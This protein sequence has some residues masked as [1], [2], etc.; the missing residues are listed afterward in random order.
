MPRRKPHAKHATFDENPPEE[1]DLGHR[2]ASRLGRPVLQ[3][4]TTRGADGGHVPAGTRAARAGTAGGATAASGDE[5][6]VDRGHHSSGL[7]AS[8]LSGFVL[9][10]TPSHE[11]LAKQLH[12]S[13]RASSQRRLAGDSRSASTRGAQWQ[14]R[15][16]KLM[17]SKGAVTFVTGWTLFALFGAEVRTLG[18]DAA[19]ASAF[20]YLFIICMG[21]FS[22]EM[23]VNMLASTWCSSRRFGESRTNLLQRRCGIS[24]YTCSFYFLLD[25]VAILSLLP[26]VPALYE[27]IL[28]SAS[29][30]TSAATGGSTGL[31]A[32]RAGRITRLG[33]RVGRL[34]RMVRLFRLVKLYFLFRGRTLDKGEHQPRQSRIGIRL[35]QRTTRRVVV[36]VLLVLLVLPFFSDSSE[37]LTSG[38][39]V[40]MLHQAAST[41]LQGWEVACA[42]FTGQL[43][44]WPPGA[45]VLEG[46]SR[47]VR[48]FHL[49]FF[50]PLVN[51]TGDCARAE[52][53]E[54]FSTL[55]NGL[56]DGEIQR[57][58][59]GDP[60]RGPFTEAWFNI[61]P[62][63]RDDAFFSML[64][65]LFVSFIL[66]AGSLQVTSDAQRLVLKPIELLA[67]FLDRPALDSRGDIT[68]KDNEGLF[69]TKLLENTVKK[70]V[71]LL[72]LGF[73][74]AGCVVAA[75]H[76]V[77]GSTG[78]AHATRGIR[79]APSSWVGEGPLAALQ[80]TTLAR[81]RVTFAPSSTRGRRLARDRLS[82]G[83]SHGALG[84]GVDPT[85][86][87]ID[88]DA[89][90]APLLLD[91]QVPGRAV[92]VIMMRVRIAGAERASSVLGDRW[93]VLLN[94]VLRIVHQHVLEWGGSPGPSTP[95]GTTCTWTIDD[96]DNRPCL[97]D[98]SSGA[99]K[100]LIA[101]E[102]LGYLEQ[103]RAALGLPPAAIAPKEDHLPGASSALRSRIRTQQ[104]TT[105]SQSL[106]DRPE[107][108]KH[109][110]EL[111][112]SAAFRLPPPKHPPGYVVM[113]KNVE[114]LEKEA[115]EGVLLALPKRDAPAP[116][117]E[118]AAFA[119]AAAASSAPAP[120]PQPRAPVAR[121]GPQA[122]TRT[123]F[124]PKWMTSLQKQRNRW[125]GSIEEGA[126][127]VD[128]TRPVAARDAPNM[129]GDRFGRGES[130]HSLHQRGQQRARVGQRD[131]L[132]A[133]SSICADSALAAALAIVGSSNRSLDLAVS[134]EL[135][136]LD[137]EEPGFLLQACISLDAVW[138]I[139]GMVG[140][141]AHM[142]VAHVAPLS[143]R[144]DAI[145]RM[146]EPLATPVLLSEAFRNLLS[147]VSQR[148]CRL[149]DVVPMASSVP[150]PN[151]AQPV[152]SDTA[153]CL[154]FACD[155]W[156]WQNQ[157]IPDQP[158]MPLS[159]FLEGRFDPDGLNRDRVAVEHHA[160]LVSVVGSADIIEH[161]IVPKQ[162]AANAI[163]SDRHLRAVLAPYSAEWL[164]GQQKAMNALVLGKWKEARERLLE[165][166]TKRVSR[167]GAVVADGPAARLLLR[168]RKRTSLLAKDHSSRKP[169]SRVLRREQSGMLGIH[170]MA[171]SPLAG[172]AARAARASGPDGLKAPSERS[173][174]SPAG[175]QPASGHVGNIAGEAED[176][177]PSAISS[178]GSESEGDAESVSNVD[179]LFA[180]QGGLGQSQARSLAPSASMASQ[181]SRL[182]ERADTFSS[183]RSSGTVQRRQPPPPPP[184]RPA[185]PKRKRPK[186]LELLDVE[187]PEA[188]P[189]V[190]PM[191][192]RSSFR[193]GR[194]VS[195]SAGG[196]VPGVLT[197][198]RAGSSIFRRVSSGR[199]VPSPASSQGGFDSGPDV[200]FD[201]ANDVSHVVAKAAREARPANLAETDSAG[202]QGFHGQVGLGPEQ[203]AA[204]EDSSDS[205]TG[206]ASEHGAGP[207]TACAAASTPAQ[208]RLVSAATPSPQSSTKRRLKKL[209][210]LTLLRRQRQGPV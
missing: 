56:L 30:S 115:V 73:G 209:G 105:F 126:E 150:C 85:N 188:C 135:A 27:P 47:P 35:A 8:G 179:A 58:G 6:S 10:R 39:A 102:G 205:P 51:S 139:E 181:R 164:E 199:L 91:P 124:S 15:L 63:A 88:R 210:A 119:A 141:A 67:D 26:E 2:L 3:S 157:A 40:A 159:V 168:L 136:E 114:R 182:S 173:A 24:G 161:N 52:N 145:L 100:C 111:V 84:G 93:C 151:M 185:P 41:R 116:G 197:L 25:F 117:S 37:D 184:R 200:G 18:F 34:V 23:L 170:T 1:I 13:A 187:L 148:R 112:L 79:Q 194:E 43:G 4:R 128:I 196:E 54:L 62:V 198:L 16:A 195:P 82:R 17:A 152:D 104:P 86:V 129:G 144:C 49:E 175:L 189:E 76:L 120:K 78:A 138:A 21:V 22:L 7:S 60:A 33:A 42:S 95:D 130:G 90:P 75:K 106:Q 153:P 149:V 158:L 48:L 178:Q 137:E 118:A 53:P 45:F 131:G 146:A 125:G 50:P 11:S 109:A 98:A 204:E 92:R 172:T 201:D 108:D 29:T 202:R 154:V 80:A 132:K 156:L 103:R 14:S 31:S 192:K 71:T 59:L 186:P 20:S 57:I 32:A 46:E 72:R 36:L 99:D 203:V 19:A 167:F 87:H 171:P 123:V 155:V 177:V 94:R 81:P 83:D 28:G 191:S 163:E 107:D 162:D 110:N 206:S 180:V 207:A 165:A 12:I 127:R 140:S 183:M 55:R 113:A 38:P 121:V 77:A 169:P 147:P 174:R 133:A 69:E 142:E 101:G 176:R 96:V 160:F 134:D 61:K 166:A 68:S 97:F 65:T 193:L 89:Q 64:L 5:S 9:G 70:L 190:S 143:R 208:R 66:V 44:A 74:P 122:S